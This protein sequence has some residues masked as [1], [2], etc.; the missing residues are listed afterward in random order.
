MGNNKS[1]EHLDD[2]STI[3]HIVIPTL[4]NKSEEEPI[5]LDSKYEVDSVFNAEQSISNINTSEHSVF[6]IDVEN[7]AEKNTK[8]TANNSE[9]TLNTILP[10]EKE[11]T[12]EIPES[13]AKEEKQDSS[14]LE[15]KEAKE[16][17]TENDNLKSADRKRKHSNISIEIDNSIQT[18][19][20]HRIKKIRP[21]HEYHDRTCLEYALTGVCNKRQCSFVHH[22]TYFNGHEIPIGWIYSYYNSVPYYRLTQI[23]K[24]AVRFENGIPYQV[25]DVETNRCDFTSQY[26]SVELYNMMLQKI[27]FY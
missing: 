21:T 18:Y 22:F 19:T 1:K 8:N 12:Q 9:I 4:S 6:H 2:S 11:E 13:E 3:K 24:Y 15:E 27:G 5:Q 20:S 25:I 7:A 10:I 23:K 16:E 17:A 14:E 26:T